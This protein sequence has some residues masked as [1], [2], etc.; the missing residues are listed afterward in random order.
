V[1]AV[2][3]VVW[4]PPAHVGIAKEDGVMKLRIHFERLGQLLMK[5]VV[6]SGLVSATISHAATYYVATTGDDSNPGSES[7]PFRTINRGVLALQAGDTLYIR[8]GTY[9]EALISNIPGGT[10]WDNPVTVAAFPGEEVVIMPDSGYR[11]IEFGD[12]NQRYIVIDGLIFD[13]SNVLYNLL[14]I[15]QDN[16]RIQ[17]SEFRNL[18]SDWC[19]I[20]GLGC[21]A[22]VVDG[23]EPWNQTASDNQ[24][25][26]LRVHNIGVPWSDWG[27]GFYITS[28]NNII[29]DCEIY[30]VH[31]SGIQLWRQDGTSVRDNI[32]RN[33]KI[34]DN[35]IGIIV[36]KGS[37][38]NVYNNLIFQNDREG[39]FVDYSIYNTSISKNEIYENGA[40]G[41]WV[42]PEAT[43]TVIT[44]NHL[45]RNGTTNGQTL[46][47][48][49]TGTV[50]SD[51]VI[52]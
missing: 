9:N 16:I 17:N 26:N 31:G 38:N 33:N 39:I 37:N 40:A 3:V 12:V 23:Y 1:C 50:L 14:W 45:A 21:I 48:M 4:I 27:V 41:I 28:A 34:Y 20:I 13:G 8:S 29:E 2:V 49:G 6:V 15:W 36:A 22:I 42:G 10:S 25:S 47:D 5:A 18:N 24:F 52:E 44:G 46:G 19:N 11:V 43:N 51:N 32:V 7:E 30:A 35:H